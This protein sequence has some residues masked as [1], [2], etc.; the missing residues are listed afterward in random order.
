M[1]LVESLYPAEPKEEGSYWTV[2]PDG[3]LVPRE[4]D[5]ARS[6]RDVAFGVT[7]E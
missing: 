3:R 4:Q 1:I 7:T 5:S 2:A 6:D